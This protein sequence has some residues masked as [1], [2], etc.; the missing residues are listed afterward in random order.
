MALKSATAIALVAATGAQ[1]GGVDRSGQSVDI[2]FE[3]GNHLRFS[4]GIV[5]PDISGVDVS[6]AATGNVAENYTVPSFGLRYQISDTLA[7]AFLY[8]TPYGASVSYPD[9][10][11][12]YNNLE[13]ELS[14]TGLTGILQFSPNENVSVYGGVRY[15]SLDAEVTLNEAAYGPLQGYNFQGEDSG[16][17]GWLAGVAYEVPEIALR[18][19][20]TYYSEVDFELE[21]AENFAPGGSPDT[22]VTGPQRVHL[23]FQSGIAA[24]TLLFGSIRWVDWGVVT[25]QP[26]VPPSPLLEYDEAV[27]T[28]TLG[29][30][31]RVTEN[32]S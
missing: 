31:R 16:A 32:F 9:Y 19:A 12:A 20:A 5:Q 11:G 13:A 1:A 18:V 26:S 17:F 28:Y 8:D 29:V 10:G 30:G 4:A 24:D 22:P 14:S 21:T 15:Q 2:I 7:A 6:T 3:E 27:V 23:D 25:L